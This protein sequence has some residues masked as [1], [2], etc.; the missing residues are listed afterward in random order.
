V[1]NTLA[2][3]DTELITAVKRFKAEAPEVLTHICILNLHL[4]LFSFLEELNL[5]LNLSSGSSAVEKHLTHRP[6]D[7]GSGPATALALEENK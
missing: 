7:K 5:E 6:K 2:F 3:C 1:T 4:S